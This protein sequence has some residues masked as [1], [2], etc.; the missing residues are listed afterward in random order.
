[1]K[2]NY[3]IDK[4]SMKIL[5]S[6]TI[7]TFLLFISIEVVGQN[8]GNTFSKR[9]TITEDT[10]VTDTSGN[11]LPYYIWKNLAGKG[12]YGLK[13]KDYKNKTTSYILFRFSQSEKAAYDEARRTRRN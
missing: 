8:K 11:I 2:K 1:M 3:R 5:T 12:E 10:I 6:L 13:P 4:K 7:Y 9:K